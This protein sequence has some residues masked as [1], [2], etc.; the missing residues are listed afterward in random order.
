MS[1]GARLRLHFAKYKAHT[2]S[3]LAELL[4]GKDHQIVIREDA[5][6]REVVDGKNNYH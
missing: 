4:H 3:R 2:S 1:V 5:D 6:F